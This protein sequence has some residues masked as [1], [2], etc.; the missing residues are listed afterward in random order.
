MVEQIN[1]LDIDW[2]KKRTFVLIVPISHS[3]L[4]RKQTVSCKGEISYLVSLRLLH[5]PS[6]L[7]LKY[8]EKNIKRHTT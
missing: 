8:K 5:D 2:K 4:L 1:E 6:A 7:L 3:T